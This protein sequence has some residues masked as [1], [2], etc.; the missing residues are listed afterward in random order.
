M[1]L[2]VQADAFGHLQWENWQASGTRDSQLAVESEERRRGM[3][4]KMQVIAQRD[5]D[6]ELRPFLIA[7]RVHRPSGGWLRTVRKALGLSAAAMAKDL[8]VSPSAIFQMERSEW[9]DKISLRGLKDSARAMSCE[10]VYAIVPYQGNFEGRAIENTKRIVWRQKAVRKKKR[11]LAL[12]M[13]GVS[14]TMEQG[15]QGSEVYKQRIRK[16]VEAIREKMEQ[17]GIGKKE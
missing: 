10:V 15:K 1:G 11:K 8:R 13:A 2:A 4:W 3:E 5:L 7:R 9:N 14:K 16:L 17:E 6:R 12:A